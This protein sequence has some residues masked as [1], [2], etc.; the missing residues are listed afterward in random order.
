MTDDRATRS[1]RIAQVAPLSVRIPPRGYGGTERVIHALTEEL[2]RRGHEVT[3]F[4]AGTSHS[5]ARLVAGS[6][7]PLWQD[8]GLDVRSYELAQL[9]DVLGRSDQFDIIHSHVDHFVPLAGNRAPA[10]LISTR[11]GRLDDPGQRAELKAHRSPLVSV[12]DAQRVA[13][14]DLDLDWVATVYNG[15]NL[16]EV[17]CLGE[18]DRDYL[19]FLGRVAPEKDPATAIRVAIRAGIP[20]KVAARVDPADESYHREQV[21]PLLGHP[22]VEW[23]GEVVDAEKSRLLA[24]AI[25]LLMPIDWPEPFG[26]T[27]I[28]ALAAGTPVIAR[29]R[30]SL[31]EII[32]HGEHGFLCETE[33]E[34][35]EACRLASDLNRGACRNWALE[36]FSAERMAIN[37]ERAYHQVLRRDGAAAVPPARMATPSFPSS[38]WPDTERAAATVLTRGPSLPTERAVPE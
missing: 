17:F 26:L 3:L 18:H 13:V 9:N 19:V 14:A 15:L 35:V 33:D 1:L 30:G 23:L 32:R 4:A 20:I 29:P 21:V 22:L 28:E 27:I 37:Y 16:K 5:S 36:H 10:S 6:S 11:H 2:V 24:G 38:A 8:Q 31:P 7:V 12:S 25:A 34:L